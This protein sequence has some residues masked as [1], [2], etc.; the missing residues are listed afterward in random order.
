[1]RRPALLAALLVAGAL[2]QRRRQTARRTER[3]IWAEA[4]A[5]PD[6]R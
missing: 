6:L 2:L 1:M 3:E 4:S 5:P